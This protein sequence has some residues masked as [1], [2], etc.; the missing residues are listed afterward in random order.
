MAGLLFG[1]TPT[2]PMILSLVALCLL[3]TSAIAAA[4]PA[5]RA[6]TLDP[7]TALLDE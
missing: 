3:L 4:I 7:A 2:E 6:A 1:V 5:R